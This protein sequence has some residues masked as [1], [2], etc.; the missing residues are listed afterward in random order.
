MNACLCFH[1]P[2][3]PYRP[4]TVNAL[5]SPLHS[6]R[7]LNTLPTTQSQ[8]TK[9]VSYGIVWNPNTVV[10]LFGAGLTLTLAGPASAADLP[11]F[12]SLQ[13]SEPSN[14]LSLPTWAVHVSSVVEWWAFF[15]YLV[16]WFLF[17]IFKLFFFGHLLFRLWIL[18]LHFWINFLVLFCCFLVQQMKE[19]ELVLLLWCIKAND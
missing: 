12:S 7:I 11:L 18:S 15:S 3:I 9:P 10:A 16:R 1:K 5:S 17:M 8:P 14:A 19:T 2:T 6:A 4:T 13:F